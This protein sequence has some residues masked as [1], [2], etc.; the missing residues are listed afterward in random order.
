MNSSIPQGCQR[1]A[2]FFLR[3]RVE[4]LEVQ[5]RTTKLL[6]SLEKTSKGTFAIQAHDSVCSRFDACQW[7]VIVV[8]IPSVW[9]RGLY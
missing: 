4:T 1:P 5:C 9:F 2:N 6:T 8:G 3:R 7:Q